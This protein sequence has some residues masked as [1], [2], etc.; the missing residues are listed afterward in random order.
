[1]IVFLN[2]LVAC[3]WFRLGSASFKEAPG[4]VSEYDVQHRSLAYKYTTS[5]HWSLT[6]F[7]PASMEVQ[8]QN[9]AER[10]FAVVV[11]LSALCVFSSFISSITSSMT[12]LRNLTVKKE[13]QSRLLRK[14][15]R[16][17]KITRLLSSRIHRYVNVVLPSRQQ[18]MKMDS[19]HILQ[20]LSLPL[21]AELKYE[22]YNHLLKGNPFFRSLCMRSNSAIRDVCKVALCSLTFSQAD[23]CFYAGT[24]A[25]AM[26]FLTKGTMNYTQQAWQ[27]VLNFTANEL[28]DKPKKRKTTFRIGQWCSEPVLWT[29]WIHVGYLVAVTDSEL[30]ALDSQRF[31]SCLSSVP[32]CINFAQKYAADLVKK[33]NEMNEEQISDINI[34]PFFFQYLTASRGLQFMNLQDHGKWALLRRAISCCRRAKPVET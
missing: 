34:H 8:P 10:S 7:T 16:K 1:M 18:D 23:V 5:L 22:L 19:S 28:T 29:N 13:F 31:R 25:Q 20:K 30:V 12:S 27:R 33:L 24:K 15:L 26:Y 2:H 11:L 6:Q 21:Q 3:A 4:W 32:T 14:Y 9:T 17:H